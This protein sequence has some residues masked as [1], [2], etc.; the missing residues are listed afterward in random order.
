M[1][2]STADAASHTRPSGAPVALNSAVASESTVIF[3]DMS[4][5]SSTMTGA[6][7]LISSMM[8]S[9]TSVNTLIGS[10][11]SFFSSVGSLSETEDEETG[12]GE[13]VVMSDSVVSSDVVISKYS[14]KGSY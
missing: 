6:E 8:L 12:G 10:F 3:K 13:S 2:V 4:F 7:G 14:V 1:S 9:I 11:L 5:L